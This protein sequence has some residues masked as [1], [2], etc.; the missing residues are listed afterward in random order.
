MFFFFMVYFKLLANSY[1]HIQL[2]PSHIS[3][4][5][6]AVYDYVVNLSFSSVFVLFSI[7]IYLF[8]SLD[9]TCTTVFTR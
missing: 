2:S 8:C 1:L 7:E 5:F 9:D 6:K 4:H 3:I